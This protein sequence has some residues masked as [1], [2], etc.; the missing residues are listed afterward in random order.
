EVETDKA[1]MVMEAYDDGLLDEIRVKEGESA[2]IG[3]VIA[4]L[5]SAA[6]PVSRPED[7]QPTPASEVHSTPDQQAQANGSASKPP[8]SPLSD[9][10]AEPDTGASQRGRVAP[11]RPVRRRRALTNDTEAN[12]D[13]RDVSSPGTE[14]TESEAGSDEQSHDNAP[15]FHPAMSAL[16][17]AAPTAIAAA[18]H[19]PVSYAEA[20]PHEVTT[21]GDGKLRASPL[22]RRA[23]EEAGIDLNH[24]HGT[25]PEGRITKRD[26]DNFL[27]EQQLFKFRRLIAPREGLPGTREEFSKMRKT[28]AHRMAQSKREIPHFYVT[29]EVDMEEAVKFKKS[30][31]ATEL[32]EEDITYNDIIV[33]AT[34]L[35]LSRYTRMNASFEDDGIVIYPNINIGMAVAVEDGLIVPVIHE[36]EQKTLPEISRAAHRLVQKAAHGGFS[37]EDLSGA[38][39]TISNMG[40][41]G[42]EHFAAVIVPPQAAILAVSAVKEKPVVRNGQVV[43][44]KT[45]M[46]TVACD[47]RVIDGV[48]G[49]RF[50]NEVKRFLENPASLLV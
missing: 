17:S 46:L 34:A 50:L 39:F 49:A 20:S 47:H 26:I 15:Q 44:G 4:V 32:F 35:A 9:Q 48:V 43:V 13:G 10:E 37:G 2:K 45:M 25:G 7:R 18:P 36:C 22:A 27:R 38:T 14:T 42:V 30:L 5:R 1:D 31:E 11:M 33:K 40:M 28:I 8:E 41:L 6:E 23:A 29:L 16:Q 19:R 24:V 3:A 21:P 12:R